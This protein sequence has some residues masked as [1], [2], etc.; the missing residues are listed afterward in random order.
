MNVTESL[1]RLE[2]LLIEAVYV[3]AG[4]AVGRLEYPFDVSQSGAD[5]FSTRLSLPGRSSFDITQGPSVPDDFT[6]CFRLDS[7]QVIGDLHIQREG[8]ETVE[9]SSM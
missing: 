5:F 4:V 6:R 2:L 1:E 8:M 3:R 9:I 7:V